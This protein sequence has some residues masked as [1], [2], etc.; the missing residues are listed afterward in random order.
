VKTIEA[1]MIEGRHFRNAESRLRS[2]AQAIERYIEGASNLTSSFQPV[3]VL[4]RVAL[5]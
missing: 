4:R 5:L 3:D 2:I 1:E